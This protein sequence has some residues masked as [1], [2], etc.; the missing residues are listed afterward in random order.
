[1]ETNRW[2]IQLYDKKG[3]FIEKVHALFLT[4]VYNKD[5]IAKIHTMDVWMDYQLADWGGILDA[6]TALCVGA[7]TIRLAIR[8][9]PPTRYT[10]INVPESANLIKHAKALRRLICEGVR[11]ATPI[12]KSVQQLTTNRGPKPT[13]HRL[14]L[15]EMTNCLPDKTIDTEQLTLACVRSIKCLSE[16]KT[17]KI[18]RLIDCDIT[19][20]DTVI[21][22]MTALECVKIEGST[23]MSNH[24]TKLC[25]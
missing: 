5:T 4:A 9:T 19:D 21:Q 17:I 14:N 25:K 3:N 13:T 1:M 23:A 20:S 8:N 12:P 2:V 6:C 11:L 16:N 10:T 7:D 18:L 24:H 22:T 15:V